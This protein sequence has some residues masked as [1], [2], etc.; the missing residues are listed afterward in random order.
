[1]SEYQHGVCVCSSVTCVSDTMA[2]TLSQGSDLVLHGQHELGLAGQVLA[3]ALLVLQGDGN[4]SRQVV[5]AADDRRVG[6]GL[7]GAANTDCHRPIPIFYHY[8]TYLSHVQ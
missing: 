6:G 1:M 4:A 7:Q 3:A 5:H 2:L 8:I